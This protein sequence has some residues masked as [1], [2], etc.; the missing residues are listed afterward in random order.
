MIANREAIYAAIYA[1]VQALKDAGDIVGCSRKEVHWNDLS[2]T[3]QPFVCAMQMPEVVD[4]KLG[5][6]I[7]S[8][9]T[10]EVDLV[11]MV[12]TSDTSDEIPAQKLNIVVQKIVDAFKPQREG[13]RN[14]LGGL[15]YDCAVTG[16]IELDEGTLSTQAVAVVPVKFLK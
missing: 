15:V 7:P 6:G 13:E 1:K 10:G 11:V 5:S 9:D 2:A 14:T 8:K 16:S 3:Q 12:Q 4:Y